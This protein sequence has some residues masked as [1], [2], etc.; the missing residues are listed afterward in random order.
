M[1]QERREVVGKLRRLA[2]VAEG[3]G[4]VRHYGNL[5]R[6]AAALI[7]EPGAPSLPPDVVP[8]SEVGHPDIIDDRTLE[9]SLDLEPGDSVRGVGDDLVRDTGA[10]VNFAVVD[11]GHVVYRVE[12]S[13]EAL[14]AVRRRYLALPG[15][16]V[17]RRQW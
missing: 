4:D 17:E 15:P 12:G 8:A 2:E 5:I 10:E 13:S 7:E 11:H 6:R 1:N 14:A 16:P 9:F 3:G